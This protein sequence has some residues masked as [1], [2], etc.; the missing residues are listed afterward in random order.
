MNI[1]GK[2]YR[3]KIKTILSVMLLAFVAHSCIQQSNKKED[4]VEIEINGDEYILPPSHLLAGVQPEANWIW[5]SGE[6]KPR[7]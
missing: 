6:V 2:K 1:A 4:S 3:M 5:D 7:N